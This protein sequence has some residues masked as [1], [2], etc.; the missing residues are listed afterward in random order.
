MCDNRLAIVKR[1]VCSKIK[2]KTTR[3]WMNGRSIVYVEAKQSSVEMCGWRVFFIFLNCVLGFRATE[4]R[5]HQTLGTVYSFHRNLVSIFMC[6]RHRCFVLKRFFSC[7]RVIRRIIIIII[8]FDRDEVCVPC[9]MRN[10]YTLWMSEQHCSRFWIF[11]ISA[12][13]IAGNLYSNNT[14]VYRFQRK[15]GKCEMWTIYSRFTHVSYIVMSDCVYVL[16]FHFD[17]HHSNMFNFFDSAFLIQGIGISLLNVADDDT[18]QWDSMVTQE[19][20]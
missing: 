11:I 19:R 10:A 15:H 4:H 8:I 5:E 18:D 9:R 7:V 2:S 16:I 1:K 14:C 3:R 13:F 17:E 20:T 12:N 6:R